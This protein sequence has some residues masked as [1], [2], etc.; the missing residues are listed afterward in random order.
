MIIKWYIEAAGDLD[1]IY[2][3]YMTK[4]PR[5]AAELY[6][7]ILDAVEILK[8]QPS[9]APIEQILFGCSEDY[10]SLVVGNYKIVYFVKDEFVFIVQIFDCRQNPIKLKRTT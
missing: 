6:N 9:V 3:Y 8:T 5:A 4:S 7:K 10:R 1:K 2:D